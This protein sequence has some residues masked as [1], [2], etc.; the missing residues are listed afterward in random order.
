M[1]AYDFNQNTAIPIPKGRSEKIS[2]VLDLRGLDLVTPVDLLS[3][4][5][6]PSAKNFRLYAQQEDDRR[7]AVSSRKGPGFYINPLNETMVISNT[8][9]TGGAIAQVGIITGVHAIPFTAVDN[10]RLTRIDVKLSDTTQATGPVLIEIY[11]VDGSG[12]AKDLL[13]ES[14]FLSGDIGSSASYVTARFVNAIKLV[15]GTSYLAVLRQQ[16]DG[17]NSYS[18]TTTTAGTPKAQKTDT[19]L[20]NLTD[21]TYA[22]NHKIYTSPDLVTSGSYRLNQDS[23]INTT[24]VAIYDTMYYIDESTQ[25]L[26]TLLNGLNTAATEYNFT[27]GDGKAF[28][29]NGY[30]QLTAWNGVREVSAANMVSNGT[31][32]VDTTGWSA[33]G[34]GTGNAIARSTAQFH[35]GVA[36]LSVT[37]TAGSNVRAA[38]QTLALSANHRYKITYWV[39]GAS[40]ASNSYVYMNGPNAQATTP[41]NLTTSWQQVTFYYTP[42]VAVT[43]ISMRSAAN[44]FFVDDISIIDTGIEYIIDSD[45][46]ILSDVTFHKDRIWGKTAADNN[47]LVFSENPGNPSS[48]PANQQ[49]YYAWLSV[50]YWYIPRPHNGSPVTSLQSFQDSLTITTQDNK[51]VISGYDRGSFNL[52]QSTGSKGALSRRGVTRDENKIYLVGDDGFYEHDGSSDVKISAPITPLFDACGQKNKITPVNWGN[53]VRF[54]M[55]SQGSSINDICAIYNKELKEWQLDTSVYVDRGLYYT[56]ADDSLQLVEFSSQAPVAY[57]AEQGYNSLGAAIDFEYDLKYDSM[58]APGQKKRLKRYY[59]ILQGVDSTFEI[60]LAMDK[61]FQ[62]SPRVKDVLMSTNGAKL[63]QFKLGDGTILGGDKSF[64]QHRQSYS[65]SAYYWQLRVIRKG[66]DNRVAFIGSEYSYKTK[67]L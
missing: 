44:D 65:G 35:G 21:Q 10:N 32:E 15:S 43:S 28:W 62:D 26:V 46:P 61:D 1:P 24:L 58:G 3:N 45:L 42:T 23:G 33:T 18:V 9:S 30:D 7:V 29:V 34:G 41:T 25:S 4:G 52:R 40:A 17:T 20:Y 22:I 5:H 8:S 13:T 53:E 39:K 60:Q 38:Q 27:N 47:K 19:T 36:S 54:Y 51:Y 66:V 48:S 50:S 57:Y 56:D 12:K 64:K 11:S 59:P 2:T 55:S 31:F 63:G 16:D 14:S 67:R 37:A 49:W 6:T